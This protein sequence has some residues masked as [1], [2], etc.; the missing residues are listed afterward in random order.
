M[1]P[2]RSVRVGILAAVLP[3]ARLLGA[4]FSRR[5]PSSFTQGETTG[6]EIRARFGRPAGQ[7]TARVGDKLVTTLRYAY[8]AAR[9]TAVPVRTRPAW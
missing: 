2:R 6:P 8:A 9:S 5:D 7:A 3:G 4:D 1:P